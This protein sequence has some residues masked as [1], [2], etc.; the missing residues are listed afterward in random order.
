M[1]S[2]CPLCGSR[3]LEVVYFQKKFDRDFIECQNCHLVYIDRS[4]C[5]DLSEQKSRYDEHN[6]H[7]PDPGYLGFLQRLIDPILE[8][9]SF[10]SKGLD[11]GSG[12]YPMLINIFNE[13]GFF[14]IQGWDPIYNQNSEVLKEKNYDF[15]TCCEVIEHVLDIPKTFELFENLLGGQGYLVISTGM[16]KKEMEWAKWYYIQD[17]THINY[18]SRK[19][20][21]WIEENFNFRLLKI[22]KDLAIFLKK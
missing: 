12:P 18:F 15:I 14:N 3:D 22:E 21:E 13:K 7:I 10:D 16:K 6:N 1:P 4:Q 11:Y 20:F 9:F 8:N 2:N 5:L 17:E 19:T